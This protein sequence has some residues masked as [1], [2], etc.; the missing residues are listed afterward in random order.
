MPNKILQFGNP[1]RAAFDQV[2]DDL[3]GQGMLSAGIQAIATQIRLYLDNP[4]QG[5]TL[6][7]AI[8]N[9][10]ITLIAIEDEL[11]FT[12]K[13]IELILPLGLFSPEHLEQFKSALN[14]NYQKLSAVIDEVFINVRSELMRLMA[15]LEKYSED[16]QKATRVEELIQVAESQEHFAI[17]TNA[18][19]A[20]TLLGPNLP[21]D[22]RLETLARI[23]KIP[24]SHP[25]VQQAQNETIIAL[26]TK[27][28]NNQNKPN[29]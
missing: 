9:Q 6:K 27:T 15:L 29:A 2:Y 19:Y 18:L 20:L 13:F 14:P 21:D 3:A 16:I 5:D 12:A 26:Q 1:S 24:P 17:R 11:F 23:S 28:V 25:M 22:L 10:I 7:T 4:S 8:V